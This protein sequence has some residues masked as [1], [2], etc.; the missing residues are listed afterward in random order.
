[1][2]LI[3]SPVAFFAKNETIIEEEIKNHSDNI[4]NDENTSTFD[5]SIIKRKVE[6]LTDTVGEFVKGFWETKEPSKGRTNENGES[7][8]PK[9]KIK[10][11]NFGWRTLFP[12][13]FG[14]SEIGGDGG[15][16]GRD[17]RREPEKIVVFD[18][19]LRNEGVEKIVKKSKRKANDEEFTGTFWCG[20][21]FWSFSWSFFVFFVHVSIIAYGQR[22]GFGV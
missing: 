3:I 9:E 2:Y 6:S 13:D 8:V 18:D 22:L 21:G 4:D 12:S 11:T 5:E 17:K 16:S 19:D 14:M 20:G 7:G 1:M 15:E 10:N